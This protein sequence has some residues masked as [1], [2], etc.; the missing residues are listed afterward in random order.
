MDA[1][2][3]LSSLLHWIKSQNLNGFIVDNPIDLF[4]LTGHNVSFGRLLVLEG[5]P[6]FFV[7]GRYYEA[8]KKT[9]FI[10]L[11][12][13]QG[14]GAN[15]AFA[16]TVKK[17]ITKN[18]QLG[19][20]SDKTSFSAYNE[21]K[22]LF[23]TKSKWIPYPSPIK[24]LRSIKDEKEIK[25]LKT[26]ATLGSKGYDFI[27]TQ[28]KEG[29][30]EK[31]VANALK[32]FFLEEGGD[33]VAFAPIIAFGKSSAYPHYRSGNQQLKKGDAVLIDIG[34]VI[35][36]YHSDM[37]RTV[38]FGNPDPKMIEIYEIVSEAQKEA[39]ALCKPHTPIANVD[40]AARDFIEKKGYG[41]Y[42][43]HSLGHGIGLEIHELPY[44]RQENSQVLLPGMAVTVEP[45]I[46]LPGIGGVRLEDSIIITSNGYINLTKRPLSRLKIIAA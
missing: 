42:F 23:K 37:T 7:D 39:L 1:Q 43:T 6:I 35:N 24:E 34:V 33:D 15:S 17:I 16:H 9:S 10:S 20:D 8:C 46:Y 22:I 32:V 4:Y 44:M 28:L 25:A 27:L 18:S 40:K 31:E 13:T 38:F 45:G 14:Y 3:H 41:K 11:C 5:E 12:L 19:F 29:I 21:L 2:K 30:T 36:H 26:A